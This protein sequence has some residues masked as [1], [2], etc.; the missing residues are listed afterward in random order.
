LGVG[1]FALHARQ[2]HKWRFYCGHW[3]RDAKQGATM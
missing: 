1:S 2:D 3:N